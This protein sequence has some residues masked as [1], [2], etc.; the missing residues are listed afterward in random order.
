[1]N[2]RV[3]VQVV[4]FTWLIIKGLVRLGWNLTLVVCRI[5]SYQLFLLLF[6]FIQLHFVSTIAHLTSSSQLTI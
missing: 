1:L 6:F 3:K 2:F 5:N 4:I